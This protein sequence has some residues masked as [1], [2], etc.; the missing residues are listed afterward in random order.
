MTDLVAGMGMGMQ[1]WTWAEDDR[2]E[3][4]MIGW[5]GTICEYCFAESEGFRR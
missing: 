1:R 4:C 2:N 5:Y 3:G